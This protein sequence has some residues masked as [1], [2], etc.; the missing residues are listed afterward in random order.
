MMSTVPSERWA[1]SISDPLLAN[2]AL[3]PTQLQCAAYAS[4][5]V[6]IEQ[7]DNRAFGFHPAEV[8]A[9]DPQQRLLLEH[10]YE[11]LH[12]AALTR[13]V[14]GGSCVGVY[15]GLE[16]MD[17]Q[18]VVSEHSALQRNVLTGA[19]TGSMAAARTSFVLGLNGPNMAVDTSCSSGLVAASVGHDALVLGNC[20][21]ALATATLPGWP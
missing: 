15:V 8:D 19:T 14:L 4:F 2:A 5:C 18:T 9:T 3:S 13:A 10:G 21:L 20:R 16:Y 7:F 11:A 6:G 12:S 17:W 1:H